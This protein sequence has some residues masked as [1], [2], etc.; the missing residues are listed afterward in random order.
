VVA[1]FL[2]LFASRSDGGTELWAIYF[3][4]KSARQLIRRLDIEEKS[5]KKAIK[6]KADSDEDTEVFS[7]QAVDMNMVS[8]EV[9]LR[10]YMWPECPRSLFYTVDNILDL[11]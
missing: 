5:S 4:R 8:L 9:N 6:F 3:S 10:P 2:F 11:P 1:I 7:M